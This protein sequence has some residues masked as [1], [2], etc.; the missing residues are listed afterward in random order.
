MDGGRKCYQLINQVLVE[1]TLEEVVPIVEA[2]L[3]GVRIFAS[4]S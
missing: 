4:R 2:N 3:D 1:R